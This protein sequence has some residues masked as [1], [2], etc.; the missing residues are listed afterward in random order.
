MVRQNIFLRVFLITLASFSFSFSSFAQISWQDNGTNMRLDP[1]GANLGIGLSNYPDYKLDVLDN[2]LGN[3]DRAAEIVFGQSSNYDNAVGLSVTTGNGSLNSGANRTIE[4]SLELSNGNSNLALTGRFGKARTYSTFSQFA[5]AEG[6]IK[7]VSIEGGDN[8]NVTDFGVGG[9]FVFSPQSDFSVNKRA[10]DLYLGGSYHALQEGTYPNYNS[11]N[12]KY[13]AIIGVD[14]NN[15]N[16]SYAGIFDGRLKLDHTRNLGNNNAPEV[17]IDM[18]V[19]D[20]KEPVGFTSTVSG[21]DWDNY[22]I[23]GIVEGSEAEGRAAIEGIAR[24]S[25]PN[26][27]IAGN[28]YGVRG[29]AN[30][31]NGNHNNIGLFGKASGGAQYQFGSHFVVKGGTYKQIGSKIDITSNN[32]GNRD[33]GVEV[34]FDVKNFKNAPLPGVSY[35]FYNRTYGRETTY[36]VYTLSGPASNVSGTYT[37][38]GVYGSASTNNSQTSGYGVYGNIGCSNC[39]SNKWAGYFN[40]RTYVAGQVFTPSDKKLK[41]EI[42]TFS[43]ALDKINQLDVKTY[44]FKNEEY[45]LNLPRGEQIGLIAE[46]LRKVFPN[47]VTK[48]EHD[49]HGR[50]STVFEYEIKS[51]NYKGLIP[52]MIQAIQEQDNKIEA[53][54]ETI[55]KQQAKIEDLEREIN[56]IK[57]ELDMDENQL[58]G[59]QSPYD[60][61]SKKEESDKQKQFPN[62]ELGQNRPNPFKNETIIEYKVGEMDRSAYIG[63][64]NAQGK[65]L[66][67][68]TIARPGEGQITF[69]PSGLK[70][71]LYMYSLVIDGQVVETKQMMLSDSN[72]Y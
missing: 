51:V 43:R 61:D 20:G 9:R 62:S 12:G 30:S 23:R 31:G 70:S 1:S 18:G 54:K 3:G 69:N 21:G 15:G 44:Q 14:N 16:N 55:E 65:M 5:G 22:A 32:E 28:F 45:K 13:G 37:S 48:D 19:S 33:Y 29:I 40:G 26:N 64:M 59:N 72:N 39:G 67:R 27:S 8:G 17:D 11:G 6:V 38:Y 10:N 2:D 7:P 53:Q 46:D 71:G 42:D 47:L 36:G 25:D 24:G 49:V 41:R 63:I 50:D 34:D 52:P 35:G 58:E 68:L 4:G 57:Q 56:R 66:K 60:G